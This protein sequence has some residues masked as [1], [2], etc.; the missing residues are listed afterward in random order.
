M[1]KQIHTRPTASAFGPTS[2]FWASGRLG[3]LGLRADSGWERAT[4]AD[5]PPGDATGGCGGCVWADAS[6][7]VVRGSTEFTFDDAVIRIVGP[8][9]CGRN[10]VDAIK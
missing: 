9:N 6:A 7:Q 5:R 4:P 8:S 10:V 2:A 1:V 3:R